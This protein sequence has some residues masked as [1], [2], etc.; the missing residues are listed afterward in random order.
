MERGGREKKWREEGE[1]SSYLASS[2]FPHSRM[3]IYRIRT[4]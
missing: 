4:N 2:R 1:S 3:W